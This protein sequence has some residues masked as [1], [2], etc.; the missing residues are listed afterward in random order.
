MGNDDDDSEIIMMTT[1]TMLHSLVLQVEFH[2][3]REDTIDILETLLILGHCSG[4]PHYRI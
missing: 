4:A 1:N 2:D 3:C